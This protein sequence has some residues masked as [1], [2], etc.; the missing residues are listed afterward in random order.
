[1]DKAVASS[2]TTPHM[3]FLVF[4]LKISIGIYW[5]EDIALEVD[6]GTLS[7][8]GVTPVLAMG[9]GWVGSPMPVSPSCDHLSG[10]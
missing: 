10:I 7:L 1:M 5:T 9:E 8:G 2:G 6:G 3:L 4:R